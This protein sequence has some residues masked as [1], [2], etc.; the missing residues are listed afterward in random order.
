MQEKTNEGICLESK[1]KSAKD[2]GLIKTTWILLSEDG[3]CTRPK[4]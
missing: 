4:S 3:F 2:T 1:K